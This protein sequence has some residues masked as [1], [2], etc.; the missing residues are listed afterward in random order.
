MLVLVQGGMVPGESPE[1]AAV[2]EAGEEVGL[3]ELSGA[4]LGPKRNAYDWP[5]QLHRWFFRSQWRYRGQEQ[6]LVYLSYAGDPSAVMVDG[7]EFD[8]FRWVRVSDL[9]GSLHPYRR[10]LAEIVR[11]DLL[12]GQLAD[13]YNGL[14]KNS[15]HG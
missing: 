3:T 11:Y 9:A 4:V 6:Y 12:D 8:A 14:L 10:G 15:A 7:R 5:V 2:R 1:A 13:W